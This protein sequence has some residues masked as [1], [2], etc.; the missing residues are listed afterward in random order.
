MADVEKRVCKKCG[1]E[2]FIKEF[3]YRAIGKRKRVC[4]QCRQNQRKESQAYIESPKNRKT[5]ND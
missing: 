2:K 3:E 4:S 5:H 1:I